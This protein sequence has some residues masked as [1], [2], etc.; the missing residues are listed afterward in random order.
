[1]VALTYMI[2]EPSATLFLLTR[3]ARTVWNIEQRYAGHTEVALAPEA[4]SQIRVLTKA[5]LNERIDAIYSSP[6]SRCLLTVTPTAE[7]LSLPIG[8]DSRLRERNLG[9]WEGRSAAELVKEYP[10]FEFPESAYSGQFVIPDS[11]SLD[12]V[13]RRTHDVLQEMAVRHPGQTILIATH[14]GIIWAAE[15]LLCEQRVNEHPWPANSTET[16]LV[17]NSGE[18]RRA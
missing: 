17:W 7:I 3:H 9:K 15:N 6:L 10:G 11:E 2:L 5:L 8:V 13:A 1:M 18:L 16:R 12:E 14:A 4:E